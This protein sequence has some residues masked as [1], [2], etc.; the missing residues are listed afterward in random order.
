[1][2]SKK[3]R[4]ITAFRWEFCPV[5]YQFYA[6]YSSFHETRIPIVFPSPTL[7]FFSLLFYSRGFFLKL[8]VGWWKICRAVFIQCV[9]AMIWCDH[10]SLSVFDDCYFF[11]VLPR[12]TQNSLNRFNLL[13]LSHEIKVAVMPLRLIDIFLAFCWETKSVN[14][15]RFGLVSL[16]KNRTTVCFEKLTFC[17]VLSEWLARIH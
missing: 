13:D 3:E 10:V 17:N 14:R 16:D 15:F 6:R 4:K 8:L 11:C 9:E 7:A 1:M 5:A 2:L 12:E